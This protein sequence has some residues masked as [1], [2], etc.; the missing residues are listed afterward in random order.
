VNIC[1]KIV[2]AARACAYKSLSNKILMTKVAWAPIE[3]LG[4]SVPLGS[5][6]VSNDS[7]LI[8]PSQDFTV[9]L[10]TISKSVLDEYGARMLRGQY[11]N[12][13]FCTLS[14]F[15]IGGNEGNKPST[16]INYV[17]KENSVNSDILSFWGENIRFIKDYRDKGTDGNAGRVYL[18]TSCLCQGIGTSNIDSIREAY[19]QITALI[20]RFA[21]WITPYTTV[22]GLA[23]DGISNILR[24]LVNLKS[25]CVESELSLYPGS[26][27]APLPSGD[28][29]LQ[30]GSYVFFFEDLANPEIADL[31]LERSGQV[32]KKAGSSTRIPPYLVINIVD[33]IIDA[34]SE[35]FSRAVAVDILEKYQSRY[36]LESTANGPQMNIFAEGLK[37]IGESY[38]YTSRINRYTELLSKG[39]NRSPEEAERMNEIKAEIETTFPKI[40]LL[41]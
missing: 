6:Y 9:R 14:H 27:G 41:S 20:G 13:Y 8:M 34:P 35:I 40:Q 25:E 19:N 16:S 32:V 37:K 23:I 7:H 39:G 12:D 5:P 26:I 33:G 28:A 10:T 30:R 21:P 24:K 1:L 38:Y 11:G 3:F 17:A 31:F 2:A 22:G 36:S 15:G 18:G 4:Q 29:Y